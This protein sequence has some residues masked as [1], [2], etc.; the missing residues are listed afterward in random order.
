MGLYLV[1]APYGSIYTIIVFEI[2]DHKMINKRI[3]ARYGMVLHGYSGVK[4]LEKENI[5]VE[6]RYDRRSAACYKFAYLPYVRT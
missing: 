5:V 6:H 4:V 2:R 3:N 1:I